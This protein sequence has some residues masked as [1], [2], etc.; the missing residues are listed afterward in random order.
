[1]NK[2]NLMSSMAAK[3][4]AFII[5]ILS[6]VLLAGGILGIA[7]M[8]EGG[9][10]TKGIRYLK[11]EFLQS[12]SSDTSLAVLSAVVTDR[13]EKY[14]QKLSTGT[15]ATYE[16]LDEHHKILWSDHTDSAENEYEFTYEK[17]PYTVITYINPAFPEDDELAHINAFLDTAYSLR[18]AAILICVVL[19]IFLISSFVFLMC[20]A[21]HRSGQTEIVSDW[22]HRVPFEFVLAAPA[23]LIYLILKLLAGASGS[24]FSSGGG[25]VAVGVGL[26]FCAA[27][28]T[29]LCV[30]FAVRMKL[31]SWWKNTLMYQLLHF[32]G[33]ILKALG[34]GLRCFFAALPVVWKTAVCFLGLCFTELIFMVMTGPDTAFWWFVE[35]LLLG[36]AAVY[37]ALTLKSLKKGGEALAQ[38]NLSYQVDTKNMIWDLKEHGSHLN[39]IGAVMSQT[40]EERMKSERMKAELVTNVS[41]D[42]KTPLTSII[43]YS[44]L[45]SRE[46]C[47][48]ENIREYAA[49]LLKQ[50]ERLKKMLENLIEASKA[51][52][53]NI[54][55]SLTPCD[56]G[57]ILSQAAGEYEGRMKAAGLTMVTKRP[58]QLVRIMADGRL[59][60]RVFDNLLNNICKYAQGGTRVYV[61][62]AEASGDAI[63]SFKNT[64]KYPLDISAEELTERFVRGDKS[65]STEGS[66]LG[67]SIAKNLTELQGGAFG[68]AIDGDLFKATLK[69]RIIGQN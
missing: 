69:F 32:A 6:S 57:V 68:L 44:D 49:V 66:G 61:T 37:L 53:G 2:K 59:L 41:H 39:S 21:G 4:A 23:V 33:C 55:V 58:D 51:S 1:M 40:I 63:I 65:R 60:W 24:I 42:I 12:R 27:M 28:G 18:Y 36:G 34:H 15:N 48:N 8:A 56:A 9:F 22:T 62:L 17:A 25:Y 14:A 47:E 52:T 54:E 29:A 26:A 46:P 43:N 5:I 30:N 50:S 7:L 38:G 16:I 10:Y 64:S 13:D 11:E 31:G 45:I 3:T 35:K 20:A 19:F 67:L